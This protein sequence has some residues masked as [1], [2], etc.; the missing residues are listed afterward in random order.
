MSIKEY[1]FHAAAVVVAL[2]LIAGT[3]W[4]AHD[5]QAQDND[6]N[7]RLVSVT[8]EGIVR[9]QPDMARVN[10]GVVTTADDPETARRQNA[11]AS[12]NAM[13]AVRELGIEERFIRL[14]TVQLQ[15]HRVYDEDL[16]RYVE[17]GYQATRQVVAEVHDLETLPALIAQ[18]VQRGVNRLNHVS[19]ELK[20]RD[21]ARND[22][23]RAAVL[24]AR[25][26]AGLIVETLGE[27]LGELRNA[28]EQSFD[29]PRPILRM[30]SM[31]QAAKDAAPEPDA[32]AA[33]EIEVRA[34]VHVTFAVAD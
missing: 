32:Y 10:F 8:G 5:A 29:F 25:D 9:V 26:K 31:D 4:P 18:I 22:A 27:E 21:A 13:N 2:L 28:N 23:I 19:Y 20:D 24:N 14:E 15:R 11:E 34:N 7:R 3:A 30:E 33:G 6:A 17:R 12:R 16:R 1:T